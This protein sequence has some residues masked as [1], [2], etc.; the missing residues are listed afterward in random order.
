MVKKSLL[1]DVLR[2]IT[3]NKKRFISLL[4][5]IIIGS[6]FYVGLKST[7][8]D[9]EIT[10]KNFYKET[11]LF[12][13]KTES[14]IGI[15][16]KD[17]ENIK[18][19]EGIDGVN[20]S[21]TLDVTTTID[22]NNYVI[23]LNSINEDKENS[24]NKLILTKG[25]YPKTINEGLVEEK[26]LTENNLSIGDLVTLVPSNENDLRAKKIK[27]VGVIKSSYYSSKDRGTSYLEDGKVDYF[28]YLE[29]NDFNFDYYQEAFITIKDADKYDTYSKKYDNYINGYIE[30]INEIVLKSSNL[31]YE[32]KL[33]E[34]NSEIS[35]L[36]GKL[37]E[38]NQTD[39]PI[40]SLNDSIKEVSENLEKEKEK[41]SKLSEVA[42]YST[43]R[44]E[45]PSFYEYKFEIERIK[46]ISNVFSFVFFIVTVLISLTIITKIIEEEKKQ[47]GTLRAMGYSKFEL[48]FKYILYAF[49]ISFLGSVIGTILFYKTIPLII[50][51]CYN[52]F[53]D[54]PTISTTLQINFVIFTILTSCLATISVSILVFFTNNRKT[55][56]ELMGPKNYKAKKIFL[57]KFTKIWSKLNF[58][59][60]LTIKNVF[61][62]KKRFFMT[63][64]GICCST[65]LILTSF[66]IK[67]SIM[68]IIGKQF[69]KINKYDMSI[70]IN[71]NISDE[72]KANIENEL[73]N[74]KEIK[75]MILTY[76]SKVKLENQ[77]AY[78]IIPNDKSK[79]N[80]FITLKSN[81][82]E[83]KLKDD[84]IILS[85]KLSNVLGV[86]VGQEIKI[87][88]SNNKDITVKVSQITENY[89]ENY[90]YMSPTLYS[91]LNKENPNYTTIL[92]KD[93]D[94]NKKEK[95]A[96]KNN[97]STI[98]NIESVE[99]TENIKENYK[100]TMNTLNYIIIIFI[101]CAALLTFLV[102]YNICYINIQE[103]KKE[104]ITLKSLGFYDIEI[105]KYI[106]KEIA[107][108]CIIGT[109]IGVIIGSFLACYIVK[110]C[111]INIFMFNFK[112]NVLSYL[113]TIIITLFFVLVIS[114]FM[115]FKIKKLD[116][117]L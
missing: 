109:L 93:N 45:T 68:S 58:L 89:I 12:D 108:L 20:L 65:A 91:K 107:I 103:R 30:K 25:R 62:Y 38:L 66:G 74:Q 43:K 60:K 39:L 102:L 76:K 54:M 79:I 80:N 104:L 72:D 56:A 92:V 29:E 9:M 40:E 44:S 19:I 33:N 61:K 67:D 15:S 99:L 64:V 47:I 51:Y 87:T 81:K 116:S 8:K 36:E 46:S 23:K 113:L 26:F 16:E 84:G 115:H 18:N 59:N 63:I 96:L 27:I 22:N 4:L 5:I 71:S 2:Q 35:I 48:I 85:E 17:K 24:I 70:T 10:A 114:I 41:L 1:K 6:G 55:P 69:D 53:Y 28:M 37:N 97:I 100:D 95:E 98:N 21:K 11:N 94:L 110:S 49:L 112:I 3:L 52:M 75:E 57:E 86:K 90:V 117:Q 50:G 7:A 42:V 83:L 73:D 34:I 82:K 88:L 101:I 106:F 77:N 32:E 105:T 14:S 13:L 31:I 111:E 78:L